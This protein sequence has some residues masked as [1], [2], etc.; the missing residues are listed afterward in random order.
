MT[1]LPEEVVLRNL[2]KMQEWRDLWQW[3]HMPDVACTAC[4]GP[5][6]WGW[7]GSTRCRATEIVKVLIAGKEPDE[8]MMPVC[9]VCFDKWQELRQ[10]YKVAVELMEG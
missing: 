8:Q 6:I 10:P 2:V 3:S 4:E 9:P 7:A 1:K 5:T